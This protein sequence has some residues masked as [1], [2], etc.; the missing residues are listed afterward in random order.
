MKNISLKT[1]L[2]LIVV[3][4]SCTANME[5]KK[6][7]TGPEFTSAYVCPMHCDKSGSDTIGI[8]PTCGMDYV[9]NKEI[10]Q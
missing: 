10:Q 2:P 3:F 4:A 6:N 9:Q 1:I 7:Q 5:E 8:C